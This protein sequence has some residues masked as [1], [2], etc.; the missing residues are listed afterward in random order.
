ML[1]FNPVVIKHAVAVRFD[2]AEMGQQLHENIF[3]YFWN[4]S[5]RSLSA[6]TNDPLN[7][8][9]HLRLHLASANNLN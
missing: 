1:E 2:C 9:G 3:Y 8:S 6:Q 7:V 5:K 4:L